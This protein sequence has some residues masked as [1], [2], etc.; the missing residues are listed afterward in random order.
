[1]TFAASCSGL[2]MGNGLLDVGNWN[3]QKFR[4][5]SGSYSANLRIL[6]RGQAGTKL[7]SLL[8]IP[9][10]VPTGLGR[11][12]ALEISQG[13]SSG[14]NCSK[15]PLEMPLH[16]LRASDTARNQEGPGM[17]VEGWETQVL[18]IIWA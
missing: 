9:N 5:P 10:A 6:A 7:C 17:C 14:L 2:G 18:R 4:N 1:M 16:D 12:P 3:A 13:S 8:L 11:L 15:K